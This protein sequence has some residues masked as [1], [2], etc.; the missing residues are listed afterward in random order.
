MKNIINLIKN[1]KKNY[2]NFRILLIKNMIFLE[3]K[4]KIKKIPKTKICKN[5]NKLNINI[6][7]KIIKNPKIK[8][9]ITFSVKLLLAS[10]TLNVIFSHQTK[11]NYRKYKVLNY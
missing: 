3:F 9:K 2:N 1:N 8:I 5:K 7:T 10:P 6:H 11:V 4:K